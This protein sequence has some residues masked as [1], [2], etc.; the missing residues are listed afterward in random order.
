V[1]VFT[2]EGVSEGNFR[3]HGEPLP[4]C[5]SVLN[6][7]PCVCEKVLDHRLY[8]GESVETPYE[9]VWE[10]SL[11]YRNGVGA[12]RRDCGLGA[13]GVKFE[14]RLVSRPSC[15]VGLGLPLF[16]CLN[17]YVPT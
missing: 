13:N 17:L 3:A 12:I 10:L 15:G 4:I 8:V 9:C 11:L 1:C 7:Q 16:L 5:V 14:D 6:Y 2:S